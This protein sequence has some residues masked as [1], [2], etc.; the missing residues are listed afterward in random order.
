MVTK[1]AIDAAL[2]AHAQWKKRLQD[3]ISTGQSEF[4]AE[5]VKKDNACQFGQW[6]YSLPS[7]DTK[8]EDFNNVK[9]LHADF[10]TVAGEILALAL[11]GKKQEALKML[12]SSGTY[13]SATGKLVL[14]LQAWKNK[15]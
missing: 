15:I 7:Q 12:E 9:A 10:H 13:G 3:A 4:K 8:S 11:S 14:A 5:V 2:A 1:E 6:L